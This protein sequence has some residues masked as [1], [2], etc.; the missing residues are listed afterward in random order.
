MNG[1]SCSRT[2]ALLGEAAM[3]R[4]A[5]AH[6]LVVGVGGVGSWCAEAL[7]RTGAGHLTLIDDDVVAASN[8]NRQCQA[9]EAT[10]GR[11]KVDALRERLLSI[12]SC[13]D[14][15]ARA[16]RFTG[17]EDISGF[18]AVVDAIDSVDSK[19]ALVLKA[20]E[21]KIP[22]VSS[23]G[24]A[25]RTDPTRVRVTRFDKVSGDGL[26]RALRRRFRVERRVLP[27]FDCVWSDEPPRRIAVRGSI[28]P[29]TAS[30]G[31]CLASRVI[32]ILTD[33]CH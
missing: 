12:S 10:L 2:A 19:A 9:T 32:E 25:L 18:D 27:R 28:M 17:S 11:P 16:V 30:F 15:T 29:V 26:A 3:E 14:V 5:S 6:V 24:A 23:M 33:F 8:L 1:E 7:V 4:L 22:V 21:L 20:C 31:M 13:A